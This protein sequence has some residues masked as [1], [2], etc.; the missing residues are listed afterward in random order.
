MNVPQ[1]EDRYDRIKREGR[2]QRSHEAQDKKQKELDR[3]AEEKRMDKLIIPYLDNLQEQLVEKN[4]LQ[5]WTF[6]DE[7]GFI[8]HKDIKFKDIQKF[9]NKD[10]DKNINRNIA[11]I[12]ILFYHNDK[13]TSMYRLENIYM[14]VSIAVFPIDNIGIFN[15]KNK[16]WGADFIWYQDDFKITKFSFKLTKVILNPVGNG[17]RYPSILGIPL[18]YVVNDLKKMGIDFGDTLDPLPGSI[19]NE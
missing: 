3:I 19:K 12:S 18:T 11:S 14:K 10:I 9:I 1:Q 4:L 2:E 16:A 5:F 15:G 8:K 7:P 6:P 17:K 13:P